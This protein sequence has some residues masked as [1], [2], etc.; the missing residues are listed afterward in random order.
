MDTKDRSLRVIL[1]AEKHLP[2]ETKTD[3]R[4]NLF[5]H[6]ILP[7]VNTV[8]LLLGITIGMSQLWELRKNSDETLDALKIQSIGHLDD[9]IGRYYETQNN[10]DAFLKC[11]L[12]G[13]H[14]SI[15]DRFAK[16]ESAQTIYHSDELEDFRKVASSWERLG[17][18][19]RLNYIDFEIIY[20]TLPFPTVFWKE[21]TPIRESLSNNWYGQGESLDDFL[22]NMDWLKDQYRRR[23]Q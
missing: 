12:K 23:D 21:T 14:S 1:D 5:K 17:A 4:K 15:Q 11:D 2:V 3:S 13:I 9:Y 19:I 6:I 16:G 8:S 20:E 10:R 7:I 22:S 18:L